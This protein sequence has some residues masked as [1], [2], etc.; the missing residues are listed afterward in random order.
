M[1]SLTHFSHTLSLN[2][3]GCSTSV[4]NSPHPL[5]ILDTGF[6]SL[7]H[8]KTLMIKLDM[9]FIQEGNY[10]IPHGRTILT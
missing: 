9:A 4:H 1:A 8:T 7:T 2:T 10:L 5:F 3:H 6:I